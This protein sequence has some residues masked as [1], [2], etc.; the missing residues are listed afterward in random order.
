MDR[1]LAPRIA[2]FASDDVTRLCS[3]RLGLPSLSALLGPWQAHGVERVQL[4]TISYETSTAPTF[5]L[6]F[7]E[8]ASLAELTPE[9]RDGAWL[10]AFGA[11]LRARADAWLR[12]EGELTAVDERGPLRV[13]C[14]WL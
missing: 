14:G 1:A 6:R 13:P 10:D 4:H 8:A 11:Q 3:E 5:P 9:D 2:V 12:D 7:D